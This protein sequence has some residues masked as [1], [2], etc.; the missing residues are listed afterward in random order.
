MATGKPV[1]QSAWIQMLGIE[2][3][4]VRHRERLLSE[5]GGFV[6]IIVV[7]VVSLA[8]GRHRAAPGGAGHCHGQ[9]DQ[10]RCAALKAGKSDVR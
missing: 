8:T 9:R 2:F 3:S 6:C 1:M 10:P 5:L 4:P 7:Y